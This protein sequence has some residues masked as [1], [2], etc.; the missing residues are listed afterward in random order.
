MKI[1][2]QADLSQPQ[3]KYIDITYQVTELQHKSLVLTFPVWT[4]G[5]YLL[6]EFSMHVEA[7]HAKDS[8]GKA[9]KFQKI[10][11]NE[12]QV[13]VGSKTSVTVSYKLYAHDLSV[14]G[15][16]LNSDM[17]F[18]NGTS[19]FF[20]PK[21][22]LD[23]P[24]TL[25]IKTPKD[26]KAHLVKSEQKGKYHFKNFDELFDTPVLCAK[27]VSL[28]KFKVDDTRFQ[29][30]MWGRHNGD[31]AKIAKD[32]QAIIKKEI[33]VFGEHPCKSYLF[34]VMFA[35]GQFG[36]LEHL[37]SSANL[38]DGLKLS[39]PKHYQRFLSLL[40]HEHFH[41]WNVK[42][43][44][45]KGLGPFDYT[46]EVYTRDL[47]IAEGITS[48]YDDHFVYRA[49]GY[50]E[51][52]YLD[53][54]AG[55]I[56]R[57]ESSKN[58]KVNSISDSSFDAWIKFY[59]Q[60]E[61]SLNTVVSYYLK[62][63]L[64]M[65]LLDLMM[66]QKTK[67]KR[68]L[69]D[70]MKALYQLYM[71]RPGEGIT[72]EE[73]FEVVEDFADIDSK[74]FIKNYIE[75]TKAISWPQVFKPFG[76]DLEQK[77]DSKKNYMG[78]VLKKSGSQVVIHSVAEDSPAHGSDLQ[79]GDEIVAINGLRV[80]K[81]SDLDEHLKASR[82]TVHYSRFQ[83]LKSCEFDLNQKPFPKLTLARKQKITAAQKKLLNQFLRK[84]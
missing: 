36:G 64:V 72:R 53:L 76:I 57:L 70:V 33:K 66:L 37:E 5:S 56:M 50:T 14:R 25:A 65:M 74:S 9:L 40:A 32:M 13:D 20:F 55:N 51:K 35:P 10:S 1:H 17:G 18:W 29:I 41:L 49:G 16:Y 78:V 22:H 2:I 23:I 27:E 45:P 80:L 39:D 60:N 71:E 73:F 58:S 47:W 34:I 59:R 63:G 38:F 21:D 61:N 30:V 11:K 4:P 42:R 77:K 84:N 3:Q 46:K 12:W 79:P 48:Y 28:V 52:E 31:E 6:R 82:V 8:N 62:G 7:F 26:W 69:D 43:I 67:G 81:V 75:G 54:V 44:R 83:E 15:V 68:N 19:A 24:V